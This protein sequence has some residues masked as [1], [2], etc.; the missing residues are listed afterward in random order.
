MNENM[1]ALMVHTVFLST[2]L[3]AKKTQIAF[4]LIKKTKI[5]DKYL[6]Y[7]DVFLEEKITLLPEITDLNQHGIKLQK[8]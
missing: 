6:D 8:G 3:L 1:K 5:S 2:I 7:A 4:V